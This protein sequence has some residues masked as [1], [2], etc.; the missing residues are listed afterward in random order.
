M[1]DLFTNFH[2]KAALY[3]TDQGQYIFKF[4]KDEQSI[5]KSLRAQEVSSAFTLETTDSGWITPGVQRCGF[6]SLGEWFVYFAKPCKVSIQ[7]GR[8]ERITVPIPATVLVGAKGKF[9]LFA[10][11]ESEFNPKGKVYAAPFPNVYPDGRICWGKNPFPKI[12][13][14]KA[15]DVWNLFFSAPFNGDLA[16]DKSKT[17]PKDIRQQLKKLSGKS[18]YPVTTMKVI[19]ETID[20][21]IDFLIGSKEQ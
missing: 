5:T 12:N 1:S 3:F 13:Q 4:K 11:E 16:S 15:Q 6:N 17:F 19:Y 18:T 9:Y 2:I 14:E 8:E 20:K 10:L 21:R 7:I